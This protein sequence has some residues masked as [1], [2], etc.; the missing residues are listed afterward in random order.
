MIDELG[1]VTDRLVAQAV[2]VYVIGYRFSES[3][4]VLNTIAARGN[5]GLN[6]IS[7]QAAKRVHQR[8]SV[9]CDGPKGLPVNRYVSAITLR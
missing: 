3:Q 1:E 2:D 6:S 5:T 8:I 4:E 7:P 9:D